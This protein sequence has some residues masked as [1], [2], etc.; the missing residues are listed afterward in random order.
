MS[1]PKRRILPSDSRN[2]R[3]AL[4]GVICAWKEASTEPSRFKRRRWYWEEG[5]TGSPSAPRRRILPEL[6]TATSFRLA[7]PGTSTEPLRPE[8]GSM[9]PALKR[10]RGSNVSTC[11]CARLAIEFPL[12]FQNCRG[13]V[14]PMG[15]NSATV[16]MTGAAELLVRCAK[17]GLPGESLRKNSAPTRG[18]RGAVGNRGSG[19]CPPP[20]LVGSRSAV[21]GVLDSL[22]NASGVIRAAGEIVE[23]AVVADRQRDR[24]I[25]AAGERRDVAGG[26][27]EAADPAAGEVGEEIVTG[28]VAREG[29]AAAA[30]T[31]AAGGVE[32]RAD[33]GLA[34]GGRVAVGVVDDRGAEAKA[35]GGAFGEGPAVVRAGDAEVDLLP[36]VLADVVDQHLAGGGVEGE[37]ERVA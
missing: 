31:S 27:V 33:D 13:A 34:G 30:A 1:T 12:L 3:W 16:E 25:D 29:A 28:V 37:V 9:S 15:G 2:I 36:G 7:R 6:W 19:R 20:G 10:W 22:D 4:N 32:G 8:V 35:V 11:G 21:G 23:C 14:S 5:K 24:G 17:D 18:L 26:R